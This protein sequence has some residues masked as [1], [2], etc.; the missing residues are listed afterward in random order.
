MFTNTILITIFI[1]FLIYIKH[2]LTK[3]YSLADE[4]SYPIQW[5]M[6]KLMF[7]SI[8]F[9][10][11]VQLLAGIVPPQLH[12]NNSCAPGSIYGLNF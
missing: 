8:L 9:M 4:F 1:E 10:V 3:S 6:F 5:C 12:G 7:K 11:V 2:T